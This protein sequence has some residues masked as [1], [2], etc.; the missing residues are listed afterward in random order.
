MKRK[1]DSIADE[2]ES[3]TDSGKVIFIFSPF[4]LS[5]IDNDGVILLIQTIFSQSEI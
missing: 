4:F 1:A 2:K 5:H 3:D